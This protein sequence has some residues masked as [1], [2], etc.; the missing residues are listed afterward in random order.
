[1]IT[2]LRTNVSLDNEPKQNGFSLIEILISIALSALVFPAVI[3]LMSLSTFTVSQGENYT[4]AYTIAQAEMES[5]YQLKKEWDTK[6]VDGKS[7]L[8]EGIFLKCTTISSIDSE[9]KKVNV[10]VSWPERG[11]TKNVAI[12]SLVANIW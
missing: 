4:K 7:C 6:M 3:A 9:E 10:I 5:I 12:E 2:V 11:D 8:A 1:M